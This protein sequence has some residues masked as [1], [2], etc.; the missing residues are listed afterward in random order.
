MTHL[1]SFSNESQLA[2]LIK[3]N[4]SEDEIIKN[5]F[6]EAE[7]NFDDS[8]TEQVLLH[9]PEKERPIIKQLSALTIMLFLGGLFASHEM[10]AIELYESASWS[11]EA[12]TDSINQFKSNIMVWQSNLTWQ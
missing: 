9:L 4:S 6:I 12:C 11:V 1:L 5:L 3:M 8:F 2:L 7:Q 10:I